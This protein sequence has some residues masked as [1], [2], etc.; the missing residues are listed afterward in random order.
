MTSVFPVEM[1]GLLRMIVDIPVWGRGRKDLLGGEEEG[2]LARQERQETEKLF[3]NF[4]SLVLILPLL[5]WGTTTHR[6]ISCPYL[7]SP[8]LTSGVLAVYPQSSHYLLDYDTTDGLWSSEQGL[9][10]QT[11]PVP[12]WITLTRL[13]NLPVPLS[14]SVSGSNTYPLQLLRELNVL[15]HIRHI[16]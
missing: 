1:L 11:P 14:S 12:K 15:T 9:Q 5:T 16:E 7:L 10:D 2:C 4:F 3:P 6:N 13:H 8:P